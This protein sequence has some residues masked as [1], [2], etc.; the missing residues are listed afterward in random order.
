MW[1]LTIRQPLPIINSF[2]L[3][4]VVFDIFSPIENGVKENIKFFIFG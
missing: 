1:Y 4:T 3:L 2:R